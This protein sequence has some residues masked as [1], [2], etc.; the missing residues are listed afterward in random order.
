[1]RRIIAQILTVI[2]VPAWGTEAADIDS[3]LWKARPLVIFA[4]SQDDP[5]LV[6]QLEWLEDRMDEI[7]ERDVVVIVD[8]QSDEPSALRAQFHPRD[9]QILLIGKDGDVKLRKPFPWNVRELSRAIDKM[10]MR[11]QEIQSRR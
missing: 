8:V 2:A 1:M 11:L 10:P 4:P 6:Q 9:F 3:Y 5:R 7:E